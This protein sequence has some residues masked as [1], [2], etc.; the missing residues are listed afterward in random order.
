MKRKISWISILAVLAAIFPLNPG[1]KKREQIPNIKQNETFNLL[2]IT[3]DAMRADRI[4]AFGFT[5]ALT[6]NIDRMAENGV[7]FRNCYAPVP[8]SLPSHCTI[9]TGREPMAHQ[10]RN[11]GMDHLPESEATWAEVMKN[12]GYE[13]YALVSS[14]MLHSKFGLKQGFD[15]FDDSLRYDQ[16]IHNA[17]TAIAA[18]SVF[19]RFQSWL[20][21]RPSRK[22]F[23]WVNFSDPR[24]PYA[25]PQ[26]YAGM[27][28][29]DPYSGEVA[30]VDHFIGE[31]VHALEARGLLDRTVIVVAGSCGEAFFEHREWGHG[32][33]GYEE[34]LKVPLILYNPLVFAEKQALECRVRLLD[35]MPSVL[36]LFNLGCPAGVQGKSVLPLLSTK[37][38]ER[39][40][41]RPV[42][43]ESMLGFAERGFAPLTGIISDNFKFISL[44][45]AELY[46][47][48]TD[49]AELENLALKKIDLAEKMDARL[50]S[51][52]VDH[53][54]NKMKSLGETVKSRK[55]SPAIDP[56]KGIAALER[57]R[58]VGQLVYSDQLD[59]AEK[60]LQRIRRDYADW[61]LPEVYD[62]L[63]LI[64]QK[65]N[66]PSQIEEILKQA[67]EKYPEESRFGL[68]LAQIFTDT[69]RLKEAEKICIGELARDSRMSQTHIFLGKIYQKMGEAR[70]ALAHFEKALEQ[71]SLNVL[72]Q[73]EC[74]SQ[75]AELGEKDRSLAILKNLLQSRS[76]VADP[77]S[78]NIRASIGGLLTKLGEFEMANTL[79]LDIVA[80]GQGNSMVWTQIGLGYFNKGN[81]EKALESF[82]K[83]LSLDPHN[84]LALSSMGTFNLALFRMQKRNDQLERAIAY[85]TQAWEASPRM[86]AAVNGLGVALKYAGE[87]EKAIACWKQALQID[88]G[89]T[90]TYFNLGITLLETGRRQEAFKYLSICREKYSDRLSANEKQQ[91]DTLIAETKK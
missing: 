5:N 40:T 71:E 37:S 30:N 80:G 24:A 42:Y 66:S 69:G 39:E 65:K 31:M 32:L 21:Q 70:R 6:P 72:L 11:N 56:K 55:E 33:F 41:D 45:E 48:K 34:T 28:E 75:L 58:K 26:E 27:F 38:Q 10:V 15:T 86:V 16:I 88:P 29:R 85:Y 23:A 1:C 36:Q 57:I 74:A 25:P 78:A 61:T 82:N 49:P 83:A 35:L 17:G 50:Q 90:N 3:I 62:S 8:Q 18:D 4:G 43:F 20:E 67:I 68:S 73:V 47:L 63:Y 12:Y 59:E 87:Y 44:P 89:F 81:L 19:S 54:E 79:L 60:E 2:L 84:S 91:L 53:A 46:D 22:F 51:Y 76:L 13:T 7:M 52:I 77:G 14:Y 9:F 64:Y